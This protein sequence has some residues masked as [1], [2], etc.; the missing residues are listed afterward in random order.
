MEPRLG[1]NQILFLAILAWIAMRGFAPLWA[2]GIIAAWY[3]G[4][5]YLEQNGTL[6]RWNATRVLGMILMVRTGRGKI[7]L[8][9]MAR[10]RRFWRAYG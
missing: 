2:V 5:L 4:L 1:L 7:A 3:F 10:P 6:D 8:E 9:K